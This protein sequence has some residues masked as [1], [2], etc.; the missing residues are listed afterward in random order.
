MKIAKKGSGEAHK[1]LNRKTSELAALK[2]SLSRVEE[3]L[4]G[5]KKKNQNMFATVCELKR[6]LSQSKEKQD[7]QKFEN[8]TLTKELEDAKV[9]LKMTREEY[10]GL[11]NKLDEEKAEN[12]ALHE[13]GDLLQIKVTERTK[14]HQQSKLQLKE[15]ESQKSFLEEQLAG[16]SANLKQTKKQLE[17]LEEEKA[18]LEKQLKVAK[19]DFAGQR[20]NLEEKTNVLL[21][22]EAAMLKQIEEIVSSAE[23]G[24]LFHFAYL[25]FSFESN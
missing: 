13:F 17:K 20:E 4:V 10:V 5:A 3:E 18:D 19:E 21:N 23:V 24:V 2:E 9:V 15:A 1:L 16:Q 22:H 14:E 11:Q 6:S 12:K 7:T 25:V 8:T